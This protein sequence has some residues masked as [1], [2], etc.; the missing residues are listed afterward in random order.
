LFVT[1]GG[2]KKVLYCNISHSCTKSKL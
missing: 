2:E 1:A